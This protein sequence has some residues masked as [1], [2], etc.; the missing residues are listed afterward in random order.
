MR[1]GPSLRTGRKRLGNKMSTIIS[2][3][4]P[5]SVAGQLGFAPGDRIV[6]VNG[7]AVE[8]ELDFQFHFFSGPEECLLVGES[9]D[10]KRFRRKIWVE[11]GSEPGFRFEPFAVK[12]CRNKC[13]FC[14]VRQLPKGVRRGLRVRDDDF[15]LSF[16]HGNYLSLTNLREGD[17]RRILD[18]RISPLYVSVHSTE[19]GLRSRML[20]CPAGQ[21]GLQTLWRLVRGGIEIHAQIVLCP[22]I[23]DGIHLRKTLDRLFR[24]YPGIASVA[25]VP[26]GLTRHRDRLPELKPVTSEKAEEVVAGVHG[27]QSEFLRRS[28]SRFAFLADEF[29]LLAG[30]PVPR[31]GHYE[32]FS[33]LEDGIGMLASFRQDFNRTWKDSPVISGPL[34]G[35]LVTGK[36][37]APFLKKYARR[38]QQRYGGTLRVAAVEN[39]FLGPGVTVA[40]LLSGSDIRAALE[41]RDLGRW[42]MVP[43]E[44]L[45]RDRRLFLDDLSLADLE[46]ALGVPVGEAQRSVAGFFETLGRLS[47][48]KRKK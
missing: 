15:R 16:L 13:I 14:F 24:F 35:T 34:D 7:Q 23:N 48:R 8:D 28:G 46:S 47:S 38:M 37:F 36:L 10:G 31:S 26:V 12:A 3:I 29:Y 27:M 22:E 40:G 17:I 9:P 2:Q 21:C 42:V 39:R 45:S 5:G 30:H 32:G 6:S 41:G 1:P 44:T 4:L 18:Q 11:E 19:P 33:Q 25:I 43:G 20:G